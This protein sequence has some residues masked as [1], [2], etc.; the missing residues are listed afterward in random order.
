MKYYIVRFEINCAEGGEDMLQ[1]AREMLS[2]TVADAGFE[3]FEDTDNGV[4][5]YVQVDL[6]NKYI[7]DEAIKCFLLENTRITYKQED[8]EDKNWNEAWEETGFEPIVIG[9]KCVIHDTKHDVPEMEAGAMDITIEARQ[10]FGTG[11]HETTRMISNYLMEMNL[12]GKRVLDCGCGTG[13]LS[14][15]ASK[16]GAKEVVGYDI[17]EWSVENTKH[18][19]QINEVSNIEVMHGDANVIS[20]IS[21][22]FDIVLANINRNILLADIET[23]RSVM[24]NGS[25]LILSGFY[26]EDADMLISKAETLGMK[27]KE[28]NEENNWCMLVFAVANT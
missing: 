10:A 7:L 28:S 26:K 16:Q 5:G 3:S 21:G 6:F 4:N 14:I 19:A 25:L 23:M 24:T 20:H 13:I 1:I 12:H 18:N 27:Y 2:A 22:L 15:I 8:A 17:D 11:T 9:G